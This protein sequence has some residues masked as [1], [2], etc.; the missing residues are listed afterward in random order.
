[1]RIKLAVFA[2][3]AF[4]AGIGG[5]LYALTLGYIVPDAFGLAQI[6]LHF[7]IVVLGGLLSLYGAVV[8]AILLTVLPELLR[9]FQALQEIVYGLVLMVVVL[10]VPDGLSGLMKQFGLLPR[11]V[12]ARNWRRLA[13]R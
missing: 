9:D 2:L 6:T 8:G 7:S 4:Y 10:V 13:R 3:S 1:V 5:A 11:E 12:M